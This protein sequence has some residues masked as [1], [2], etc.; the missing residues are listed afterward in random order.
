MKTISAPL[1]TLLDSGSF[2]MADLYTITLIGGTVLRYTSADVSLSWS[3]NTFTHSGLLIERERCKWTNTLSVDT[4]NIT[5]TPSGNPTINS[6]PFLQALR[7]GALDG[8]TVR[9]DRAFLP[10]GSSTITGTVLLFL[11]RTGEIGADR[12]KA[13]IPVNSHLELLDVNLPRNLYQASCIWNLF[14]AGCTLN[15]ATWTTAGTINGT[16]TKNSIPVSIVQ[17]SGYFT[18]GMIKFLSGVMAGH[19][20]TVQDYDGAIVTLGVPLINT[21]ANGDNIELS[22]GCDW[23]RSTCETKF[24]NLINFRGCPYIPAVETAI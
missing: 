12:L 23:T 3:G 24:N 5:I 18:N 10:T 19:Q 13:E 22:A 15:K 17:S 2:W 4:L 7:E 11:G 20:A 8:S 9:L 6:V 16:P 21:P 14:D 1:Q